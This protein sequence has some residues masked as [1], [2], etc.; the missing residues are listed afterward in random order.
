MSRPHERGGPVPTY[1]GPVAP[2]DLGWTLTHEHLFVLSPELDRDYPHPEWDAD[3]AVERAVAGLEDLWD[4][5]VRTVVDLTVP[6]LGRDVDLVAR[7]ASRVRVNLVASTGWYADEVL[8]PYFRTH[9]PDRLVGG[10]D[11]L[12]EMFRRDVTEGIG[13]SGV[14]AGMLKVVTDTPG[15]TPDVERVM[16]AAATVHRETGVPVTTHSNPHRRN[17]LDQAA[18]L[19][20]RGVAPDHVV[21]GHSG[22]AEDLDYL[23]ALLDT[24]VTLGMD[25]FGMAHTGSDETRLDMVVE[26]LAR[27]H[28]DQMVLSHDAAYFSRVTPPSWRRDHT[29]EWTHDHLSRRVLPAL[30]ERGARREDVDQMMVHNAARLLAPAP[31]EVAV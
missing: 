21:I 31:V 8:P 15:F 23:L 27:G 19:V 25:R 9:G 6:G 10:P 30:L 24:G 7:V 12:V 26:L 18:Y 5:G 16:Q 17:G 11:P 13:D 28:A 14:R 1:R 20:E 4:L 3:A 29:P 22:D 2:E